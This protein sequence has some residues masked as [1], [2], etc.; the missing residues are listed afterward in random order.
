LK[1]LQAKI[2][3]STITLVPTQP[4]QSALDRD[5][6]RVQRKNEIGLACP[7]LR[8]L[9]NYSTNAIT[10]CTLETAGGPPDENVPPLVLYRH[11]IEATDG[12]EVLLSQ[13]CVTPAVPILRSSFEALLQIEYILEKP[14]L[15]SQRS[16][17]WMLYNVHDRPSFAEMLDTSTQKGQQFH[18]AVGKKWPHLIPRLSIPSRQASNEAKKLTRLLQASLFKAIET[19]YQLRNRPRNWYALLVVHPTSL[20][21]LS[22]STTPPSTTFCIGG[23]PAPHT[24]SI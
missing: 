7:L 8:E 20:R 22:I 21:L 13:A 19:D 16:L 17:S 6:A 5:A 23:S 3:R 9:V 14:T 10:R 4:L 2:A 11:V 18:A 1:R 15:Y 24:P 12:I